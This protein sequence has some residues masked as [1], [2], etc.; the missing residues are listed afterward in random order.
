MKLDNFRISKNE[1]LVSK[2]CY[3]NIVILQGEA[4]ITQSSHCVYCSAVCMM[5][6]KSLWLSWD[7]F[8]K[9]WYHISLVK[10]GTAG[11]TTVQYH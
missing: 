8:L 6:I 1:R 3:A 7:N 9:L 5:N 2:V 4:V 10:Q 11:D